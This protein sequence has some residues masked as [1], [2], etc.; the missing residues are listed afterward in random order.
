MRERDA[1]DEI[2]E[3]W[4][5]ERPDLSFDAMGTVGR[6]GRV[7]ALIG[8]SLE[9]V[10]AEHGLTIADFD[11]LATLRRAGE[12]HVARPSD[13]A[14]TLMLSPEDSTVSNGRG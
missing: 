11:V 2:V 1:V 12:P 8:A 9:G 14:R 6:L 10:F 13:I 5:R 3:Q 4:S 7:M